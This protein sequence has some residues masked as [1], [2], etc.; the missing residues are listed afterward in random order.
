MK[1][2]LKNKTEPSSLIEYRSTPN[3]TYSGYHVGSDLR[4]SLLKE[5][6]YI[7]CYCMQGITEANMKVEHFKPQKTHPHLQL[8]Y[9]NMLGACKGLGI[10]GSQHCDTS[11]GNH[12]ISLDPTNFMRNCEKILKYSSNGR[13]YAGDSIIDNNPVIDRDLC[14]ILNLNLQSL[15]DERRAILKA[16]QKGLEIKSPSKSATIPL[17][18]QKLKE[19][20]SKDSQGRYRAYCQV[21]IFYLQKRINQLQQP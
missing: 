6:G 4:Q 1:H 8:N 16:L 15:C 12:E 10:K 3:A 9:S 14:K 18:K 21:A 13:I 2:I 19:W 20:S 17:L 7:C 5:Q 11:K